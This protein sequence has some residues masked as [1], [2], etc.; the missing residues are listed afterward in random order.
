MVWVTTQGTVFK[1]GSIRK[2][3][4]HCNG[5]SNIFPLDS[6]LGSEYQMNT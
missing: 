5:A 1:G 6:K 2:V 4:D 3:E